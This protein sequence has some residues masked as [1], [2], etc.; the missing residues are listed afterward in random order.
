[1]KQKILV[2]GFPEVIEQPIGW[3]QG[4]R[5]KLANQYKALI[6]PETE[7]VFSVVSRDYHLIRHE[8]AIE[9]VDAV[10]AGNPQLGSYEVSTSF[11]ND[12]GRMRC[13][14]SF[15]GISVEV[16][17]EDRINLELNLFNSY[18]L[19]WPFIITL[20]AFRLICSNGLI[21][22]HK[23]FC[24][25][26]RHIFHMQDLLVEE[27]LT[28]AIQKFNL[29]S[30]EWK[31][32]SEIRLTPEV[33]NLVMETMAFGVKAKNKID[34]KVCQDSQSKTDLG[35]PVISMWAFYNVLT[36]YISHCA[37]SLNHQVHMEKLLRNALRTSG[38]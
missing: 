31:K 30:D 37:A 28:S 11:F 12:G 38:L 22:G 13:K 8:E 15:P 14:Y 10:I 23:Y 3:G 2:S 29:Q 35:F 34:E 20:G 18:D 1:M 21:I 26:K 6:N 17:P 36:W 33:Y 24:L 9:R 16:A 7:K 4:S 32:W 25:R 19:S 27:E 5:L